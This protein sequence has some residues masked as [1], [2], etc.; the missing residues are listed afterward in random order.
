MLRR[1]SA[2]MAA[3]I[4]IYNGA[5]Y[6][7]MWDTTP[8]ES[9]QY[10]PVEVIAHECEIDINE[11]IYLAQVVEAESDRT[12]EVTPGKIAIAAVILNRTASAD[13]PD[14]ITEVLNQPG[15]FSTTH[16]GRCNIEATQTAAYAIYEAQQQIEAGEIPTNLLYFN[17]ICYQYGTP[18]GY[19]GGN[20]FTTA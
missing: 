10:L 13:F 6:G 1:I 5:G 15:Q 3:I 2:T 7:L 16:N 9:R 20:Y 11:F 19:I 14:T 8:E 18:Y 17:C 12:P 4:G